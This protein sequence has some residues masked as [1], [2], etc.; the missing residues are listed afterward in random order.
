MLL[1]QLKQAGAGLVLASPD[2]LVS[3]WCRREL[4]TLCAALKSGR[5]GGVHWVQL[6]PCGWN[7]SKLAELQA[8]Q[9]PA[10]ASLEDRAEG[11][12][13]EARVLQVCGR[14][15][16]EMLP[17]ARSEDRELAMVRELIGRSPDG[18]NYR[19]MTTL[20]R[21]DFSV[22]CRGLDEQNNEVVIKVLTNTPLHRMRELFLQVSKARQEV[23][24]PSVVKVEKVFEVGEGYDARIVII[25]E[26]AC[27]TTL[28][29]LIESDSRRAPKDRTLNPDLIGTILRRLAEALSALHK[30][31][32]I[33]AKALGEEGYSHVM[34][35]L[36]PSDV[37]FD[38]RTERPQ[39][40][41]V[42]VT[43]FLWHFFDPDTFRRI[44]NPKSGTYI[45]P[46][47]LKGKE[48]GQEADQYFLGM[49]A[50]ELLEAKRVF[51][52]PPEARPMGP[53]EL[54]DFVESSTATWTQH[55]QLKD[56]LCRL[57]APDPD[58]RFKSMEQVAAQLRALEERYRVLAKY[59]FRRWV[60]PNDNPGLSV[61]FSERFYDRFF[62]AD[63]T[64]RAIFARAGKQRHPA[65]GGEVPPLDA[66]HHRKLID[67]LKAVLNYCPG[68]EPSSIDSL[69]PIHHDRQIT[70]PHYQAFTDSFIQ[71]LK[72]SMRDGTDVQGDQDEIVNAW[73]TLFAPVLK[74]MKRRVR[75]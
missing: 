13:R 17:L 42:G 49:L 36:I 19:P 75:P 9:E 64:V 2:Y 16:D 58:K 72:D 57:L 60:E 32:E 50:L 47:K 38:E 46:E 12:E 5:L 4:T 44:V 20:E 53:K 25:S 48:A 71:T 1:G 3:P 54:L 34:G 66:S 33:H 29:T 31:P 24:H 67:S 74:E 39:I 59:S 28:E 52:L 6:R 18:V 10:T 63:D 43:N 69:I 27:K 8:L 14:I 56:L 30:Q 61:A 40:S 73:L 37:Y 21:G 70:E 68:N 55:Q 23:N 26:L 62:S 65:A 7:W 45:V 11:P 41:L 22:V 35:P 51:L 15:T